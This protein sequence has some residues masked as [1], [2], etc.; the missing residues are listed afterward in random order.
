MPNVE[1][2]RFSVIATVAC[3]ECK[4]QKGQPCA[5]TMHSG[6]QKRPVKYVHDDRSY[7]HWDLLRRSV[8][9]EINA[10]R[11]TVAEIMLGASQPVKP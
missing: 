9:D 8:L 3:P 1:S 11:I 5:E 2:Y 6:V 4:A 10:G 7:A